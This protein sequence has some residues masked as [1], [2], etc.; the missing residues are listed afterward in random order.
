MN[1][2]WKRLIIVISDYNDFSIFYLLNFRFCE[3]CIVCD[4]NKYFDVHLC[5]EFTI[6]FVDHCNIFRVIIGRISQRFKV[7][8]T[9]KELFI[10]NPAFCLVV[11]SIFIR[12]W[13]IF[14][15]LVICQIYSISIEGNVVSML[16]W[17]C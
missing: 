9:G 16:A 1:W 8:D 13:H 11:D 5:R 14:E 4:V 3:A 7:W 2:E 6:V 12:L 15:S 17:P 10:T